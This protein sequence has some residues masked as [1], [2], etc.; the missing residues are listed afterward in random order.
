MHRMNLYRIQKDCASGKPTRHQVHDP[1]HKDEDAMTN[2]SNNG[3]PEQWFEKHAQNMKE[4]L[5]QRT[6]SEWTETLL[7]MTSWLKVRFSNKFVVILDFHT[8]I[9]S[10]LF[11]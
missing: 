11:I 3:A 5:K 7:P 10:S 1:F 4:T 2:V 9:I 8:T 6:C